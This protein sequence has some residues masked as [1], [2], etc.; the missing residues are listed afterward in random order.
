MDFTLLVFEYIYLISFFGS[1]FLGETVIV[2]VSTLAVLYS[3]N[4][5]LVFTLCFLGVYLADFCWFL[6]GENKLIYKIKCLKKYLSARRI[7]SFIKSNFIK[8]PIFFMSLIKMVYGIRILSIIY[9]G[10]S[11]IKK[12]D[13]LR[14]NIIPTIIGILPIFII[15]TLIGG[16]FKEFAGYFDTTRK[17]VGVLLLAIII[18]VLL[19]KVIQKIWSNHQKKYL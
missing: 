17:I 3:F 14:W 18:A 7:P 5:F 11:G 1:I 12:S 15:G 2:S 6:I 16:G 19:N 9:L 10:H 13:F 4:I 8:R